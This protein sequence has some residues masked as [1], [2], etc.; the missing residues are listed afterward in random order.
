MK[1][2][3]LFIT[4]RSRIHSFFQ[5]G[6]SSQPLRPIHVLPIHRNH[7]IP[8]PA[9]L[10]EVYAEHLPLHQGNLFKG[11]DQSPY[12]I[13]R[14]CAQSMGRPREHRLLILQPPLRSLCALY[15]KAWCG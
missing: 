5:P 14:Y 1:L 8:R 2:R 10:I 13:R 7:Q 9:F 11:K 3:S 4:L 12:G 6:L 15:G